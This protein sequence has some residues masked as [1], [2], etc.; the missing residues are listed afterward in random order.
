MESIPESISVAL[1]ENTGKVSCMTQNFGKRIQLSVTF[2][3]NKATILATNYNFLKEYFNQLIK[4][5]AEQIV[6]TK[7]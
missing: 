4:K 7:V 3:I 1:V 5:Q 2:E 6:L